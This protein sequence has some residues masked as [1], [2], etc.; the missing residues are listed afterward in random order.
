MNYVLYT[1]QTVDGQL[2]CH[3]YTHYVAQVADPSNPDVKPGD[4][5]PLTEGT[6][7]AAARELA[8]M[9]PGV[10]TMVLPAEALPPALV[11]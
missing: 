6:A 2:V 3:A 7:S 8:V 5:V 1:Y 11:V 4:D 10:T 9:Q